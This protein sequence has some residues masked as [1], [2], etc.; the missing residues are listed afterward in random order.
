MCANASP[1]AGTWYPGTVAITIDSAGQLCTQRTRLFVSIHWNRCNTAVAPDRMFVRRRVQMAIV[2]RVRRAAV[3][4]ALRP[5][6]TLVL[7]LSPW[8][9]QWTA[10]QDA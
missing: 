7:L 10:E 1:F 6:P 2:Y 5:R 9:R 3:L 4:L 8:H